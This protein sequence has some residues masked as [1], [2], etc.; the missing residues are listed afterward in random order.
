MRFWHLVRC[1]LYRPAFITALQIGHDTPGAANARFFLED[2]LNFGLGGSAGVTVITGAIIRRRRTFITTGFSSMLPH[3]LQ[4]RGKV[5][6]S[7]RRRQYEQA[8][9]LRLGLA[10]R[11]DVQKVGSNVFRRTLIANRSPANH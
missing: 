8:T 7:A 10:P 3:R 4:W 6:T 2:W 9:I 11:Q 5:V 1:R